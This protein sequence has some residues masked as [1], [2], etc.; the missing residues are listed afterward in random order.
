MFKKVTSCSIKILVVLI[1]VM[2]TSIK[3]LGKF[4]QAQNIVHSTKQQLG[5]V[6]TQPN[7]NIFENTVNA[8]TQRGNPQVRMYIL[9]I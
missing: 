9:N 8:Q 1:K 3:E 7:A 5:I 6:F 4:K 2:L